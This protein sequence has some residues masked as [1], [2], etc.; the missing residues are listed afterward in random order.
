MRDG[1]VT[2]ETPDAAARYA[3]RLEEEGENQVCAACWSLLHGFA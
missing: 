3:T 2:F 1:V